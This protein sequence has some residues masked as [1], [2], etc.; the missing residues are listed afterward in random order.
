MK[1]RLIEAVMVG[2]LLGLNLATI[3]VLWLFR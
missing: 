1:E 2:L 3:L